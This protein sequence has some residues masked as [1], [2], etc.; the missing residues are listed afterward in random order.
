MV[1]VLNTPPQGSCSK[2]STGRAGGP[3]AAARLFIKDDGVC[4]CVQPRSSALPGRTGSLGDLP[5]WTHIRDEPILAAPPPH[6]FFHTRGK[7]GPAKFG[8]DKTDTK[9]PTKYFT[10]F[11]TIFTNLFYSFSL[12][13]PLP[14]ERSHT[15][16]QETY[17]R[18]WRIF[19]HLHDKIVSYIFP[20]AKQKPGGGGR[21]D[22]LLT[23][24]GAGG[25]HSLHSKSGRK[26]DG[27]RFLRFVSFHNTFTTFS[28]VLCCLFYFFIDY[29]FICFILFFF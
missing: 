24:F 10:I 13:A 28:F 25:S 3:S 22:E 21:Y 17:Q 8:C 19:F 11:S 18:V 2:G 9:K 12:T 5:S 20:P 27:S 16:G 26:M 29:F 6:N 1:C 4:M 15:P 23:K 7:I 14:M